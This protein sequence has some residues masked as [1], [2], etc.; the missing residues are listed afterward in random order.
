MGLFDGYFDPAQ[1]QDSGGLLGRLL[2][3]QQQQGQ[4]QPDPNFDP[5][6]PV[7][8]GQASSAPQMSVPL[9][10]PR[11]AL[12][13]DG[14]SVNP[15]T[16]DYGQTQNIAV[17]NYQMPQFGTADLSQAIQ[18]PPD[19]GDRLTAGFQNWVHTPVGNPFAALAN[20][21]AGL[22]SGQR[23]DAAGLTPAQ[24]RAPGPSPDLGD[25]LS[26][27]F[28]SW[29]HTP[30]GNP[31]AALANGI[32]GFGSGQRTDAAGLTPTR[33]QAAGP[34]ADLGDR[35]IAGFQSW[36]RTPVGNL[37]AA[38][39]NGIGGLNSGQPSDPVGMA[40]QNPQRQIDPSGNPQDL[41]AQYQALRPVLGD[42]NAMLAIVHPEAGRTMIAQALAGQAKSGI[43][44]DADLVGNNNAGAVDGGASSMAGGQWPN[45]KT[46]GYF[47][48]PTNPN[49]AL[50]QLQNIQDQNKK[51]AI[52][53]SDYVSGV[54]DGNVTYKPDGLDVTN[55][56]IITF[57]Y[58]DG[59]AKAV[60]VTNSDIA[61]I[62][63]ETGKVTQKSPSNGRI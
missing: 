53:G 45:L 14:P 50:G 58:I 39:A 28:Q 15:Q 3:L 31:F 41:G 16:P 55:G 52:S 61:H 63:K 59:H 54:R 10:M 36:A 18:Q 7:D 1:F 35:L 25:R 33:N 48:S 4:S 5:Q 20:G 30:V 60:I 32:A 23:T 8:G 24:N 46:V 17:G 37:S 56:T 42:R 11:P 27:G 26:A 34:S 9:P 13:S 12:T 21:V 57:S 29:A 6:V 49:Q 62:D 38:L 51:N 19:L 2:S 44:G 22:G 47:E 40:Q 43:I